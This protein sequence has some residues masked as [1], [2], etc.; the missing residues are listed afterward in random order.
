MPTAGQPGS[1][2]RLRARDAEAP[3]GGAA[4][5]T[6]STL[7]ERVERLER[8][9]AQDMVWWA[10]CGA[11]VNDHAK[12][13][14]DIRDEAMGHNDNLHLVADNAKESLKLVEQTLQDRIH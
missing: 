10:E 12:E 14:E 13:L 5:S 3:P 6:A 11:I 9:R 7:E 2:K 4:S 8:G 1:G